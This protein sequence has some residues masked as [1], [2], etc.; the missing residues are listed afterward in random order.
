MD[1]ENDNLKYIYIS[2]ALNNT[3][4]RSFIGRNVNPNETMKAKGLGEG[5]YMHT[6]WHTH[7]NDP[8]YEF[9]KASR[10]DRD[11]Q[12]FLKATFPGIKRYVILVRGYDPIE[13]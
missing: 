5:I 10:Y 9:L 8:N 2:S 7:P 11:T 6:S 1:T 3:S 12:K 4:S 13:F